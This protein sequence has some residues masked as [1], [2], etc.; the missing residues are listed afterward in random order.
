VDLFIVVV[1]YGH[2]I[3]RNAPF[4][5]P[6]LSLASHGAIT[7]IY[8]LQLFMCH[9]NDSATRVPYLSGFGNGDLWHI[10]DHHRDLSSS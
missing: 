7:V 8:H 6:S 2:Y 1:I 5:Y 3:I 4:T 9:V 10:H